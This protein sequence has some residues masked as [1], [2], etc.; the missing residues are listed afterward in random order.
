MCTSKNARI[1]WTT[2]I[3]LVLR[4]GS[5]KPCAA[6][7]QSCQGSKTLGWMECIRPSLHAISIFKFRGDAQR[8]NTS[9]I[10]TPA[11]L[12]H[13]ADHFTKQNGAVDVEFTQS[14]D[15]SY[16]SKQLADWLINGTNRSDFSVLHILRSEMMGKMLQRTLGEDT[17]IYLRLLVFLTNNVLN[18]SASTQ[19]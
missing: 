10:R 8:P 4:R 12:S 5:C 2:L 17:S 15:M 11:R 3:V 13:V 16:L 19:Y 1:Q 9:H 7:A 14:S 6:L 18:R